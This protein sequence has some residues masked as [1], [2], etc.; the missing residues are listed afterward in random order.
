MIT[1]LVTD[2]EIADRSAVGIYVF[3]AESVNETVLAEAGFEVE[4]REDL[5]EN[6]SAMAGRWH[7]ARERFRDDLLADEG[8][9]TFDGIQRFLAACHLLARER[10]L[11]R[12]AYL[13]RR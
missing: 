12:Y 8:A 6:M 11:S 2:R 4:R 3:S 1:G 5:T 10:R 7:D 13:A 9:E